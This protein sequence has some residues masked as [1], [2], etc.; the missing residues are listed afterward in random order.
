MLISRKFLA[1][2]FFLQSA[3]ISFGQITQAPAT[4]TL[5]EFEVI[6][7]P[8][9]RAIKID[10]VTTLQTVAG[11]A[12]IKQGNTLF[13][14]D[15]L[16][17]NPTTH[18]VEAFGNIDINQGDTVHTTGEYLRY[19]GVEKMA[20][21]K[22]N[23]KLTDKKGT[24]FTQDLDYNL[25]TG[26]GKPAGS[27]D[28]W[29]NRLLQVMPGERAGIAIASGMSSACVVHQMWS[30]TYSDGLRLMSSHDLRAS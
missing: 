18:I 19:L 14:S 24:L 25:E 4:D 29:L 28:G 16:V 20:Y 17:I 22:K 13:K 5:R 15:S 8:S 3:F 9:M 7:G 11:G 27:S 26:I 21:L 10:S 6:R 1:S 2:I 23:V 30:L 12:I